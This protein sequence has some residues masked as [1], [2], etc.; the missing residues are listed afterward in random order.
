MLLLQKKSNK[1]EKLVDFSLERR[2]IAYETTQK[3][4]ADDCLSPGDVS[5]Y[6]VCMPGIQGAASHWLNTGYKDTGS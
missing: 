2:E 3:D 5:D 1:Q 6:G 4:F